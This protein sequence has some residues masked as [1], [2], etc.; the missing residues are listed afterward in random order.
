MASTF[1]LTSPSCYSVGGGI[2]GL[3]VAF[4][5]ATA[6]HRVTVLEAVAVPK[7]VGAG[8][9]I[10]ANVSRIL[11]R[12]G[13]SSKL[14]EI[15]HHDRTQATFL[16][17]YQNGETLASFI[18]GDAGEQRYGGPSYHLHRADL[19]DML[20]DIA[21]PHINYRAGSRVA[22][23]NPSEPAVV[24]DSGEMLTADM[25]I[26][27]DGIRSIVRDIVLGEPHE[28]QYTGDSAYRFVLPAE[29]VKKDPQLSPLVE[30]ATISV[31]T[32]PQKHLV[33]YGIRNQ[34]NLNVVA[35]VEDADESA[36]YS[37]TSESDT[38]GMRAQF[39][40]WEPR[41]QN[42]LALVK[43][44]TTLKYKLMDSEPLKTWV[45]PQG[46]VALVGDAC[47]PMLPNRAQGAAMA[48]EDAECLGRLFSHITRREQIP[49]L[50]KAYENIRFERAT[51]TQRLSSESRG[52]F[53]L[54]DGP[55]QRAR[56]AGMRAEMEVLAALA[57]GETVPPEVLSMVENGRKSRQKED[58]AQYK[59]DIT[60][61]TDNWW[62]ENGV[63]MQ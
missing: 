37:W 32:G 49:L 4:S 55:A 12:W 38:E 57:K 53:H 39:R 17:R 50:L 48:I 25:V 60:Q 29:D 18:G 21:R 7:E 10:A 52:Y 23:V 13:L 58:D 19:R 14:E 1:I 3:A 40:G 51:T 8:I 33:V 35:L 15:A 61:V 22:S 47:H 42:L 43:S 9:V 56:D 34:K 44:P 62:Q 26:G 36:E 30:R 20:Y 6:G 31:W 24:L 16:Y 54:P 27:A 28:A 11:I 46:R 45:H 2:A 41:V 63:A 5:L 59:Y